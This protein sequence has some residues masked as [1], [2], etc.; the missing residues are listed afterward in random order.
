MTTFV[1]KGYTITSSLSERNI[2]LKLVD[3]LSFA[4]Y[5]ATVEQKDLRVHSDMNT[6][7]KLINKTFE[8]DDENY[9]VDINLLSGFLKLE[10]HALVGGLM[11]VDFEVVLREKVVAADALVTSRLEQQVK[12]L[13]EKFEEQLTVN[14]ELQK[15]VENMAQYIEKLTACM[16]KMQ[17]KLSELQEQTEMHSH[18]VLNG[19]GEIGQKEV[20]IRGQVH[21]FQNIQY[22]Y[23]L[24]TLYINVDTCNY[25]QLKTFASKTLEK[26]Y[27]SSGGPNM[28]C[29]IE[30][31]NLP[32]LKLIRVTP[33][34]SGCVNGQSVNIPEYCLAS[35][36][37]YETTIC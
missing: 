32:N 31:T 15:K 1:Y 14:V 17:A 4:T 35:G 19:L 29:T 37:K 25:K 28:G 12:L 6:I 36:I 3:Q 13:E 26:L 16:E 10:F 2:F 11:N 9:R 20:S 23:R 33:L 18:C 7:F 21:S 34:V 5:E 30:F 27:F 22:M 8:N 24:Q